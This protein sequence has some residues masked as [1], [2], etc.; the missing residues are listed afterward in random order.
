MQSRERRRE[1]RVR[2]GTEVRL[3]WDNSRGESRYAV[4]KT[5]DLSRSGVRVYL[6]EAIERSSYVRVQAD[7]LKLSGTAVVRDCTRKGGNYSIGLEFS[8]GTKLEAPL[9]Y[10]MPVLTDIN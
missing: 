7:G 6:M 3:V 1:V 2:R 10:E 8:G 5:Y 4:T 9:V